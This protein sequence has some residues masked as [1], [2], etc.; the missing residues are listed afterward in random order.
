MPATARW[1][2]KEIPERLGQF[3]PWN[4]RQA[5][6]AAAVYDH[7]LWARQ[8]GDTACARWAFT[9]SAYN[10]GERALGKEQTLA[11]RAGANPL[12]W[13]HQVASFRARSMASY[14]QNRGY[15]HRILLV[16]EP[17]YID[18]GWAGAAVCA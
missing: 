11:E 5:A 10:G 17:A 12:R 8:D 2:A 4:P 14:R 1:I 3:D 13:F 9:L 6:L 16:L 15:V 7:W 18:A